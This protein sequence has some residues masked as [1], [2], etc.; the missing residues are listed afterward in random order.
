[1]APKQK[2]AIRFFWFL[3]MSALHGGVSPMCRP[4]GRAR[5]TTSLGRRLRGGSRFAPTGWPRLLSQSKAPSRSPGQLDPRYRLICYSRPLSQWRWRERGWPGSHLLR[6]SLLE[7]LCRMVPLQ[8]LKPA[9]I[10]PRPQPDHRLSGRAA[11]TPKPN[12]CRGFIKIGRHEA[13][14]PESD[15]PIPGTPLSGRDQGKCHPSSMIFLTQAATSSTMATRWQGVIPV[16]RSL[17]CSTTLGHFLIPGPT[18]TVQNS[19]IKIPT[20]SSQSEKSPYFQ[21]RTKQELTTLESMP[22]L[23]LSR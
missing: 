16:S 7:R 21:I 10:A 5:T 4:R 19:G 2:M 3:F 9:L 8:G 14:P 13:V 15:A 6:A 12:R 20:W 22:I 17:G 23:I 1:M 18:P 11:E